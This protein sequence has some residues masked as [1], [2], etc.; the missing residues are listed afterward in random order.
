MWKGLA[1]PASQ[2]SAAPTPIGGLISESTTQSMWKG[3]AGPASQV[4][5]VPTLIGDVECLD[6]RAFVLDLVERRDLRYRSNSP[7]GHCRDRNVG[8]PS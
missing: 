1:G 8:L 5:A 4:S 7:G 2:V 6:L 3:L